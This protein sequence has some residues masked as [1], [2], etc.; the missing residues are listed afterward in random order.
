MSLVNAPGEALAEINAR[1][2]QFDIDALFRAHYR[3]VARMIA[4]VVRDPARAE[5][6]AVEVFLKLWRNSSAQG[7]HVEGW[8]Y[9]VALRAGLDELR[10]QSRRSRYERLLSLV[11]STPPPSTP[12]QLHSATEQQER[13][14]SILSALPQREAEFLV[15]RSHGFSYDEVALTLNIKTSSVGTLLSRAQQSFRKEFIKRYGHE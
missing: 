14:R 3:R 15:L 6:L 13:V 4:R 1:E 7:E 8:L 2:A 12:E 5:E 11:R 9:R 10:R